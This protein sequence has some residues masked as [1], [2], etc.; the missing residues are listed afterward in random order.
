MENS[1]VL[2]ALQLLEWGLVT[3]NYYIA[4]AHMEQISFLVDW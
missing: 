3:S 1:E 2:K 4:R